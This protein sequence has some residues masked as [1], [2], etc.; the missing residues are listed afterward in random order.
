MSLMNSTADRLRRATALWHAYLTITGQR[1]ELAMFLKDPALEKQVISGALTHG[2]TKL[3]ALA[4]EWLR[5]TG[6]TVPAVAAA[7][8]AVPS[9]AQQAT[10]NAPAEGA[11][12]PSRYLRGVR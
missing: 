4:Q 10:A 2:D 5:D 12:K 8:A 11:A 6:Q 1:F 3:A 9:P 7:R